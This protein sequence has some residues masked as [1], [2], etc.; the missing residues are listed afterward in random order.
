M[1]VGLVLLPLLELGDREEGQLLLALGGLDDGRD[2]LF[3]EG[4]PQQGR[5]VVVDEVDQ[6]TLDV[7]TVLGV[8]RKCR[9][10]AILSNPLF[11]NLVYSLFQQ[12]VCK[13]P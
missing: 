2:E 4:L 3:E 12:T 10:V 7:G 5:P 1:P 9:N 11:F 13:I 8:G 6:Q